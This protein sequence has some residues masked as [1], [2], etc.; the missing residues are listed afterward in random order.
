MRPA[1]TDSGAADV[2]TLLADQ[3]AAVIAMGG[4]GKR[5]GHMLGCQ[6]GIWTSDAVIPGGAPC[7]KR[8]RDAKQAIEIAEL[9][10]K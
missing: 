1:M 10:M 4:L 3:L 7:S 9:W 2:I 8:C 5:P 6:Q